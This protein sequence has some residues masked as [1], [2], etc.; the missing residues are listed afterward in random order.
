M[1]TTSRSYRINLQYVVD[2]K[3]AKA[4]LDS[5]QKS[6]ENIQKIGNQSLNIDADY[7]KIVASARD[8]EAALQSAVNVNTGKLNLYDFSRS[9]Q[10]ANIDLKSMMAS[11]SQIPG[12]GIKAQR[13]LTNMI[14]TADMSIVK[15][16]GMFTKFA[17][18]LK[19][20]FNWTMAS[21]AIHAVEGQ[22]SSAVRYVEDLNEALTSIRVV[23]G[24]SVSDMADFAKQANQSAQS[25]STTTKAFAEASLIYFQQGDKQAEAMRKA[26]ITTKAANVAFSASTKEMSEMLTAVWNSYKVGGDQLQEYVD[27]MAALGAATASSTEEI[28]TAMQKVAATANTVGVSMKQMSSIIS[29]VASVTREAP[30]V[31]GTAYKTIL[32]RMGDLKFGK[33]LEDGLNLGQVSSQLAGLGINILDANQNLRDMGSVIEEIGTKW[34]GMS[35]AQKSALAQVLAGKRQY[36]QLI[37][38]FE[39]FDQYRNNMNIAENSKGTLNRQNQI[40]AEGYEAAAKRSKAAMEELY[41][42]LID[43][44][45][46][47]KFQNGLTKALEIVNNIVKGFGGL[48][49]ILLQVSQMITS[50][51]GAPLISKTISAVSSLGVKFNYI[52]NGDIGGLYS[53]YN[54]QGEKVSIAPKTVVS[55]ILSR[56]LPNSENVMQAKIIQAAIDRNQ[57]EIK[58]LS[59]KKNATTE[60]TYWLNY[61]KRQNENL[62]KQKEAYLGLGSY[63]S[64]QLQREGNLISKQGVAREQMRGIKSTLL[65]E[66]YVSQLEKAILSN[67][68]S[69]LSKVDQRDFNKQSYADRINIAFLSNGINTNNISSIISQGLNNIEQYAPLFDID[70]DA[71]RTASANGAISADKIKDLAIASGIDKLSLDFLSQKDN[72]ELWYNT[73]FEA[74]G[75][76][77][78]G[79]HIK[80]GD[81]YDIAFKNR[82]DSIRNNF[83]NETG[84]N[85]NLAVSNVA[86]AIFGGQIIG[87]G[88]GT[89][90][91]QSYGLFG[92]NSQQQQ[93]VNFLRSLDETGRDDLLNKFFAYRQKQNE[94]TPSKQEPTPQ[95]KEEEQRLFRQQQLIQ[96]VTV[97]ANTARSAIMG[98]QSGTQVMSAL[99]DS[100]A[101]LSDKLVSVGGAASS[102]LMTFSM[103]GP[104]AAGVQILGMA[105]G[106]AVKAYE[107]WIEK[108]SQLNKQFAQSRIAVL[109]EAANTNKDDITKLIEGSYK[110]DEQ[111]NLYNSASISANEYHNNLLQI[112]NDL[113]LQSELIQGLS[114]DYETLGEAMSSHIDF[115]LDQELQE[116]NKLIRQED[117][118]FLYRSIQTG[119][120]TYGKDLDA[121]KVKGS[122]GYITL[123]N[124]VNALDG[125]SILSQNLD[126]NLDNSI[127]KRMIEDS[128]NLQSAYPLIS[129]K[130]FYT[131]YKDANKANT[132]SIL[133]SF[134]TWIGF[135]PAQN[136]RIFTSNLDEAFERI[137]WFNKEVQ[138]FDPESSEGKLFSFI[139]SLPQVQQFLSYAS[140]VQQGRQEKQ[141]TAAK[142]AGTNAARQISAIEMDK[143]TDKDLNDKVVKAAQSVEGFT[144]DSDW[145]IQAVVDSMSEQLTAQYGSTAAMDIANLRMAFSKRDLFT[146]QLQRNGIEEQDITKTLDDLYSKADYATIA[147]VDNINL[148]ISKAADRIAETVQSRNKYSK[149]RSVIS[150][151]KTASLDKT[152]DLNNFYDQLFM[153]YGKEMN[154][155]AKTEFQKLGTSEK[156]KVI[157]NVIK[158]AQENYSTYVNEYSNN[159]NNFNSNIEELFLESI[160]K[161][162]SLGTDV[163]FDIVDSQLKFVN[164]WSGIKKIAEDNTLEEQSKKSQINDL[165]EQRFGEEQA[166]PYWITEKSSISDWMNSFGED[167][168]IGSILNNEQ[169]LKEWKA[170]GEILSSLKGI[171][172]QNTLPDLEQPLE[173]QQEILKQYQQ[174]QQLSLDPST[175]KSQE[176]ILAAMKVMTDN[177]ITVSD[178]IQMS[179]L[180]KAELKI[181]SLQKLIEMMPTIKLTDNKYDEDIAYMLSS[182][183]QNEL[184][185]LNNQ[186]LDNISSEVDNL[187]NQWDDLN[188]HIKDTLGLLDDMTKNPNDFLYAS[189][190]EVEEFRASLI[191]AG[192]SLE[193]ANKLIGQLRDSSVSTKERTKLMRQAQLELSTDQ[194]ANAK[195]QKDLF[196]TFHIEKVEPTPLVVATESEKVEVKN[197]EVPV[198]PTGDEVSLEND[199]VDVFVNGDKVKLNDNGVLVNAETNEPIE[200][201]G[202]D[203]VTIQ[204]SSETVTLDDKTLNVT[205]QADNLTS[206]P[207]VTYILPGVSASINNIDKASSI[208]NIAPGFYVIGGVTG[209]IDN[210][211]QSPELTTVTGLMVSGGVANLLEANGKSISEVTDVEVSGGT[212]FL[213]KADGSTI[214]QIFND[215]IN[216]GTLMFISADGSNITENDI[217]NGNVKGGTL[218]FQ[219]ADGTSIKIPTTGEGAI[220]VDGGTLKLLNIDPPA[221]L[222]D[223]QKAAITYDGGT[224]KITYVDTSGATT[225]DGTD[226][227]EQVIEG[228]S[229]EIKDLIDAIIKSSGET[230]KTIDGGELSIEEI[231]QDKLTKEDR[232]VKV[233]AE[234]E[235]IFK[236]T[237]KTYSEL[238][239]EAKNALFD[240]KRT[241]ERESLPQ[242]ANDEIDKIK[243]LSNFNEKLFIVSRNSASYKEIKG[244]N[245]IFGTDFGKRDSYNNEG[246]FTISE[247][248]PFRYGVRNRQ[249]K[250][251]RVQQIKNIGSIIGKIST[252]EQYDKLSEEQK[253]IVHTFLSAVGKSLKSDNS[254]IRVLAQDILNGLPVA[255]A[256]VVQTYNWDDPLTGLGDKI[257]EAF[258]K[259]VRSHSP[260]EITISIGKDVAAG[261]PLGIRRGLA[262]IDWTETVA[263]AGDQISKAFTD[264]VQDS[265][266]INEDGTINFG[267]FGEQYL[268]E[269]SIN[270]L[271]QKIKELQSNAILA[272]DNADNESIAEIERQ[273]ADLTA[274]TFD[275]AMKT[276]YASGAYVHSDSLTDFMKNAIRE[277]IKEKNLFSENCKDIKQDYDTLVEEL[278][279]KEIDLDL[280]ISMNRAQLLDYIQETVN[281][282]ILLERQA[283]TEVVKI[284]QECYETLANVRKGF[285]EGLSPLESLKGD[286]KEIANYAQFLLGVGRSPNEIQ[287]ALWDNTGKFNSRYIDL[288]LTANAYRTRDNIELNGIKT[289]SQGYFDVGLSY[290]DYVS[291]LTDE[292]APLIKQIYEDAYNTY[293]EAKENPATKA[294]AEELAWTALR[295]DQTGFGKLLANYLESTQFSWEKNTAQNLSNENASYFAKKALG[296]YY[297]EA[298]YK[299][300]LAEAMGI[301]AELQYKN[302]NLVEDQVTDLVTDNQKYL[303]VLSKMFK[304]YDEY[305]RGNNDFFSPEEMKIVNSLF[306]VEAMPSRS[307]ITAK[308][309]SVNSGGLGLTAQLSQYLSD[310]RGQKVIDARV[311]R[312]GLTGVTGVQTVSTDE[313][314]KAQESL[315][316][317]ANFLNE[318]FPNFLKTIKKQIR[319]NNLDRQEK[320][321]IVMSEIYSHLAYAPSESDEYHS[322]TSAMTTK[323][324]TAALHLTDAITDTAKL[325]QEQIDDLLKLGIVYDQTVKG[326]VKKDQM[327]LETLKEYDP[328]VYDQAGIS[329]MGEELQSQWS[330][331]N[332]YINDQFNALRDQLGYK[333]DL[334]FISSLN[335]LLQN[336]MKKTDQS[337]ITGNYTDE[338]LEK[339]GWESLNAADKLALLAARADEAMKSQGAEDTFQRGGTA[340]SFFKTIGKGGDNSLQRSAFYESGGRTFNIS[341]EEFG[342]WYESDEKRNR[343][344]MKELSARYNDRRGESSDKR[345]EEAYEKLSK[346]M[347][348]FLKKMRAEANNDFNT[349]TDSTGKT[350]SQNLKESMEKQMKSDTQLDKSID[351]SDWIYYDEGKV[352]AVTKKMMNDI[353][354]YFNENG[355]LNFEQ[356]SRDLISGN[357]ELVRKATATAQKYYDDLVASGMDASKALAK[358]QTDFDNDFSTAEVPVTTVTGTETTGATTIPVKGGWDVDIAETELPVQMTG[359]LG[360][361]ASVLTGGA[362]KIG[363]SDVPLKH[364]VENGSITY[365]QSQQTKTMLIPGKP[366]FQ[367]QSAPSR[368]AGGGGGGG[369]GGGKS[370]KHE[371]HAKYRDNIPRYHRTNSH[372]EN[373]SKT[374]SKV[375]T[376]K[377][378]MYG[379]KLL[380]NMKTEI[381]YLKEQEKWYKTLLVEAKEW[382]K[383][384]RDL[385]TK[386]FSNVQF[387]EDGSIK[388]YVE[389]MKSI[390]DEYNKA[391]DKF[392]ASEQ[393]EADNDALSDA[394]EKMEEQ[395]KLIENY[396]DS[397]NQVHEAQNNILETQNKMA[398]T[399]LEMIKTKLEN[400][401]DWTQRERDLLDYINVKYE[402]TLR[403]QSTVLTDYIT[404]VQSLDNDLSHMTQTFAE[405]NQAYANGDIF[406]AQYVQGLQDLQDQILETLNSIE[407]M[408]TSIK[409]LYGNTLGLWNDGISKNT[410]LIKQQTSALN[411]FIDMTKLQYGD[412]SYPQLQ[413]YYNDVLDINR[414]MA[415]INKQNYQVLADQLPYYEQQ[416][417]LGEVSKENYELLLAQAS[418]M[419]Q[420]WLESITEAMQSAKDALA[421]EVSS[422]VQE[423]NRAFAGAFDDVDYLQEQFDRFIENR[424]LTLTATEQGYEI[425]KLNRQID[426][427]LSDTESEW[428]K[429]E[430]RSLQDII[431]AEN[432]QNRLTQYE[433]DKLQKQYEITKALADLEDARA[434]KDV[435]RLTRDENGNFMYQYTADTDKI[436]DAEQA[437]EDRVFEMYQL[438]KEHADS[439]QQAALENMSYFTSQ[440]EE[441]MNNSELTNEQKIARLTDLYQDFAEKAQF[442]AEDLAQTMNDLSRW[443]GN[444]TYPLWDINNR[445]TTEEVNGNVAQMLTNG[446]SIM[447]AAVTALGT[448]EN[449]NPN[450][451]GAL[452]ALASYQKAIDEINEDAQLSDLAR[453]ELMARMSYEA[454]YA[455]E[456]MTDLNTQFTNVSNEIRTVVTAWDNFNTKLEKTVELMQ[457]IFN[458]AQQFISAEIG[459]TSLGNYTPITGG[460]K[461]AMTSSIAG[462]TF[463][464]LNLK[465]D[466]GFSFLDYLEEYT[467]GGSH[468][469]QEDLLRSIW[470]TFLIETSSGS[471]VGG[472][473]KKMATGGLNDYTGLAWLD[474]TFT[475]PELVLNADDTQRMFDIIDSERAISE[476]MLSNIVSLIDTMANV[477]GI[478]SGRFNSVGGNVQQQNVTINADFPNVSSRDEIKAAFGDIMNMA[479]QYINS[480]A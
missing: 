232:T 114:G 253:N 372:I 442:Y 414:E 310:L 415:A 447:Q 267:K 331:Q 391:V 205:A 280:N 136:G 248:I 424:D 330:M 202:N 78:N 304:N 33:T 5:L 10:A 234:A 362:I 13:A 104:Q 82:I 196:G 175:W 160:S 135:D 25:L 473:A 272:R 325:T 418:E 316:N 334:T 165:L 117:Q 444:T 18:T 364:R 102:A 194:I 413:G 96:K 385:L 167:S 271:N 210:A 84:K 255:L 245:G 105:I 34:Q 79:K 346:E 474:G 366:K 465:T 345:W 287:E 225:P 368:S 240:E 37:A 467:S 460:G 38:L 217:L 308:M 115:L 1:A 2:T 182:S 208:K 116:A 23:T 454:S 273:I 369:G 249:E 163:Q 64:E 282:Q 321:E 435:V 480:G 291:N 358:T 30:S 144:E 209:E 289:N 28:A 323:E 403:K 244:H 145:I 285:Y 60:E 241:R 35:Q 268:D 93:F 65:S 434:A 370:K 405:L 50:T 238:S 74:I 400:V 207:S 204:A 59:G 120:D 197:T 252:Q 426:K 173:T 132:Q 229:L 152:F 185:A 16:Q 276:Y 296:P 355:Q 108:Q 439:V 131:D 29:T 148:L 156:V 360:A 395:K 43:D 126:I 450:G 423:L 101:K 401:T 166:A 404:S 393:E 301:N 389:V 42:T 421:N 322:P 24:K 138:K 286:A 147:V 437:Y 218:R 169:T 365:D 27:I 277:I 307:D 90:A 213:K 412:A 243:K 281:E 223:T 411:T 260:S 256:T 409:E 20:S 246:E 394:K 305:R 51:F 402:N 295:G 31:I 306:G 466:T 419:R 299:Q 433:I 463:G 427:D 9:L 266:K 41:S 40:W 71:I 436:N 293:S 52:K 315:Q 298:M 133:D 420:A 149:T 347:I 97:A 100:T 26:E 475:R 350:K 94:S 448:D 336:I 363:P 353:Q 199:N 379:D 311:T 88:K 250:D 186:K 314:E 180:E 303:D 294:N 121:S 63:S 264:E 141:V 81:N 159:L 113:G 453:V 112:A 429:N 123:K 227:R 452:G 478:S 236:E 397:V 348:E 70:F 300:A 343:N 153:T 216:G 129:P 329:L 69:Q 73:F 388:N 189:N 146:K 192:Y 377:E 417:R 224:L 344:K 11:F 387:D 190:V 351:M 80:N 183:F 228:G 231:D 445:S 352:E 226:I 127:V 373:L 440:L 302:K 381:D 214:L 119:A 288:P 309:Y 367:E 390:V 425:A 275:Q 432:T 386:N 430:L 118:N 354:D 62:Q 292:I 258:R 341:A 219:K 221:G 279:K 459:D 76:P 89:S 68:T 130:T 53:K 318:Y 399:Q 87:T 237:A 319:T 398:D 8:L 361:I 265:V 479:S 91:L 122:N 155:I 107:Q 191:E 416:M 458:Q 446:A 86:N 449:G 125:K 85:H 39:N 128:D 340:S 384:D 378:R 17:T 428:L 164:F 179:D 215:K 313:W 332:R 247:D 203:T 211:E 195:Y 170:V 111:S 32:A 297:N 151:W 54:E 326:Y 457:G 75:S 187:R 324:L 357:A 4:S 201:N 359:P 371:K 22:I 239:Q 98:F 212:L 317:M 376:T 140:T 383:F 143:M 262:D 109:D 176:D 36:T 254:E 290:E 396:E 274:Q 257:E 220:E 66:D 472:T 139:L 328:T 55:R 456:Q 124:F 349:K 259:E 410:N 269:Q 3:S 193:N 470:E 408:R 157:D 162:K 251:I 374:L 443:N 284:W 327:T 57:G 312:S 380:K 56:A 92:E 184:E 233:T 431:N 15:S 476:P 47:I 278:N 342:K 407:E 61:Y 320:Q 356:V 49:G 7:S 103:M 392:N 242:S 471:K 154:L 462:N 200:L 337:I 177:G 58:Y 422:I 468:E 338:Q 335:E 172:A 48:P 464:R 72:A 206:N 222:T 99:G 77:S 158:K 83:F 44:Q 14:A 198:E 406:Q 469:A 455:K 283:A 19:N 261:L 174:I 106:M 95:E 438:V 333:D 6:L 461:F 188:N 178:L 110:I 171:Q 161:F 263:G 150:T 67:Y 168:L 339:L 12:E 46:M 230:G 181:K 137:S 382:E 134:F 451:T 270:G 477:S 21:N 375:N 142:A 441:I 235:L 45:A